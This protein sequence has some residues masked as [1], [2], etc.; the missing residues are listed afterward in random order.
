MRQF[1]RVSVRRHVS[2]TVGR[3]VRPHTRALIALEEVVPRARAVGVRRLVRKVGGAVVDVLEVRGVDLR[4]DRRHVRRLEETDEGSN[5]AATATSANASST[6][7]KGEVKGEADAADAATTRTAAANLDDQRFAQ[8]LAE[9][10]AT[11]A[12]ELKA[13]ESTAQ[14][15]KALEQLKEKERQGKAMHAEI[16]KLGNRPLRELGKA[17]P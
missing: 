3:S 8:A 4:R 10:L 12:A 13:T 9:S 15:R 6:D 1:Y 7:S 11:Q 16:V 14:W 5:A 17:P 2:K